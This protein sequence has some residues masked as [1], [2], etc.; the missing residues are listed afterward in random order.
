M[1]DKT[2]HI[3]YAGNDGYR[4]AMQ[5]SILSLAMNNRNRPIHVIF[6]TGDF[7][8]LK[9]TYTPVSPEHA[10]EMIANCK[11]FNETMSYDII[12]MNDYIG[13]LFVKNKN[14]K[15]SYTPYTM[16]RLSVDKVDSLPEKILYLD[17]DTVIL[18]PIDEF[19][20]TDLGECELGMIQDAVGHIY[21]GKRYCNAGVMLMNIKKIKETNHFEKAR[22]FLKKHRLFMPDQSSINFTLKKE[23]KM[24]LPRKF[25]EQKAT[26]ED[27][28]IRH[29]CKVF[30]WLPFPHTTNIKPWVPDDFRKRFGG[31]IDE[32]LTEFEL[33]DSDK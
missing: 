7:T 9:E 5:L 22:R 18:K 10:E 14:Y 12:N 3:A 24:I 4:K 30:S 20:D 25:N 23:F 11:K 33:I 2:L 29:Y 13:D 32:I 31:E 19:Y 28:V 8:D 15:S 17:G 1:E 21:F 26:Q 27:T 16:L 6:L